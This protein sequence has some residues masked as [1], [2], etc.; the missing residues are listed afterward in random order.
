MSHYTQLTLVQRYLIY[1]L[2]KWGFSQTVTAT[3]VGVCKSTISREVK[4]N[5][6]G[7]GYRWRQAHRFA[8]AR[9]QGKSKARITAAHWAVVKAK[10]RA[11]WSPE[12]ISLRLA[13]AGVGR[14]SHEWI[15][16]F[17]ARD[18][19]AGGDLHTHLRIQK[20]GKKAYGKRSK[21]GKIQDAT[22]IDERPAVV[23]ERSRF[24]EAGGGHDY[25]PRPQ[26]HHRGHRRQVLLRASICVMGARQ[27]RER[28]RPH[29]PIRA[30]G[31]RPRRADRHRHKTHHAPPQ[32]PPAQM[33]GHENP[34]RSTIRQ[35]Q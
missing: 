24:G 21:R 30:E 28:Q 22:P 7:C 3:V 6:G 17:I 18:K 16:L 9:R 32:Q 33:L 31:Q 1:R 20:R 15:Y 19:R 11:Q 29:P 23:E 12:Q 34:K 5:T 14:V 26:S 8:L 10:L 25:R 27:Q 13:A 4:R 35:T 2:L